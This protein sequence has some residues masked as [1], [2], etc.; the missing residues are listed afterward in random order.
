MAYSNSFVSFAQYLL[1]SMKELL[2]IVTIFFRVLVV[3]PSSFKT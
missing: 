2:Q 3:K 1:A